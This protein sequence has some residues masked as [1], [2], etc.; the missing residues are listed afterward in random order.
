MTMRFSASAHGDRTFNAYNSNPIAGTDYYFA[1]GGY[2]ETAYDGQAKT[3]ANDSDPDGDSLAV[4]TGGFGDALGS[5]Y[6]WATGRVTY[7]AGYG[8]FGVDKRQYSIEDPSE[9]LAW[10]RPSSLLIL[11]G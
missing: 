1:R 10:E 5:G 4:S 3:T 6:F 2:V 7:Y 11:P 9:Q 8:F